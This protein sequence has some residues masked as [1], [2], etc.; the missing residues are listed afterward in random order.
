MLT[1]RFVISK[2]ASTGEA[3]SLAPTAIDLTKLPDKFDIR[4]AK[5]DFALIAATGGFA[6]LAKEAWRHYT[7]TDKPDVAAQEENLQRLISD[8]KLHNIGELHVILH[9]NASVLLPDGATVREIE[10]SASAVQYSIFFAWAK[11]QQKT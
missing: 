4:V 10:R 5:S 1:K 8:A 11:F 3:M 2:V 6:W 7:A 9:P